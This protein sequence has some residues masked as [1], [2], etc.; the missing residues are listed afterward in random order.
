MTL[1]LSPRAHRVITRTRSAM[2]LPL[3]AR[4]ADIAPGR[5]WVVA[6]ATL[7]GVAAT[8]LPVLKLLSSELITNAVLHGPPLG[9]IAVRVLRTGW[10]LRVEVDDESTGPP[11]VPGADA[12]TFG[13]RGIVLVET[14]ATRWGC[15]L[16]GVLGKTVWFDLAVGP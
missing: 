10:H 6:Q 3:V 4:T 12:P 2:D 13:G 1:R 15:N 7:S 5:N 14:L 9:A 11:E 8:H 16:R